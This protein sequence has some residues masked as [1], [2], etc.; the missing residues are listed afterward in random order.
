LAKE[1]RIDLLGAKSIS[2]GRPLRG[3][4]QRRLFKQRGII[5][6]RHF[7][8]SKGIQRTLKS[9]IGAQD[10]RWKAY[11]NQVLHLCH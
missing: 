1:A 6:E 7:F 3:R 8:D 4:T 11:R 5:S 10:H 2:T 9:F